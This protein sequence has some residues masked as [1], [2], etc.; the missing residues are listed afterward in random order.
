MPVQSRPSPT[1]W[2]AL[3][4]ALLG[5]AWC[6]YIAFP[7]NPTVS[8]A[9]SGCELF[10]DMRIAGI[11][12]WWVGGAYF[13][14]FSIICLRGMTWIA[15]PM[16][17]IALTIDALLLVAMYFTA[18][19]RD[20]LVV[21]LFFALTFYML[22]RFS[23]RMAQQEWFSGEKSQAGILLPL[24]I[25]LFLGN[26][27]LAGNEYVPTYTLGVSDNAA[28][29]IYFSPSCPACRDA[30]VAYGKNSLLYPVVE[31]PGD[32]ESIRRL[33]QQLTEKKSM[34]D[35]LEY[36]LD[37]ANALP[38]LS[39]WEEFF[40]NLQLLRN[41]ATVLKQGFNALPLIQINGMPRQ[42]PPQAAPKSREQ[43]LSPQDV[44][45]EIGAHT[46]RGTRT[47]PVTSSAPLPWE[48]N[49]LA[50]CGKSPEPCPPQ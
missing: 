37:A 33:K 9:S 22:H 44:V 28:I 25:G 38:H 12:L 6:G 11:S 45:P 48:M 4:F 13:F 18:P 31:R 17:R 49:D 8:C 14:L 24:W 3:I 26:V 10:R 34:Q 40:L 47:A 5:L 36:S 30:L 41:K 21:A 39:L 42:T 46:P 1:P 27:I 50:S 20:C 2:G 7:L 32:L 16:A 43:D 35:A 15:W 23:M 19:C 29:R